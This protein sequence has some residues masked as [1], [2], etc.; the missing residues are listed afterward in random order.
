MCQ[1]SAPL[2]C[3]P[4]PP[5]KHEFPIIWLVCKSKRMETL[6]PKTVNAGETPRARNPRMDP[7]RAFILRNPKRRNDPPTLKRTNTYFSLMPHS[8]TRKTMFPRPGKRSSPRKWWAS[9]WLLN[10]ENLLEVSVARTSCRKHDRLLPNPDKSQKQNAKKHAS[11]PL[12]L[13]C[14]SY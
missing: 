8:S 6:W 9:S 13:G 10:L 11:C 2:S 5:R 3:D 7:V 1:Y 14:P 12:T 4:S